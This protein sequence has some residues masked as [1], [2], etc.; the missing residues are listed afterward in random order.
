MILDALG[1]LSNAQSVSA[2]AYS[3][4]TI[5]L[6]SVTPAR[7]IGNGA[8]LA[9]VFVIT[10]AAAGDSGSMTNTFDFLA[11]QSSNADLSSHDEMAKCRRPGTELVAGKTFALDIPIDRPTKRYIGARYEPG[12]GDTFGVSAYLVP[13]DHVQQFLAYAKSYS[14]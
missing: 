6:G 11:V 14:I 1:L 5:D 8:P 4:N 12:T 9:I 2:A 10:T 7:R 3:T 13:R